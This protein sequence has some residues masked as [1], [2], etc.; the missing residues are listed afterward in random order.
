MLLTVETNPRDEIVEIFCDAAGLDSLIGQLSRLRT[1]GGH[2]HLR[3]PSW[4]G[5]ELSEERQ[6]SSNRLC[7]HLRIALRPPNWTGPAD[8]DQRSDLA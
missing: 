1:Q 4:A 3:T 6:V 8:S 2:V 5:T 7:H